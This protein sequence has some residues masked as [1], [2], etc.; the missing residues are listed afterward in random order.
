VT[1]LARGHLKSMKLS[2]ASRVSVG[3]VSEIRLAKSGSNTLCLT[4]RSGR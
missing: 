4:L 1:V 3:F 2:F